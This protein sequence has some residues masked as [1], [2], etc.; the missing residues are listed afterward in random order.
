MQKR[1]AT[2]LI[3]NSLKLKFRTTLDL[4]VDAGYTAK[5]A[6]ANAKDIITSQGVVQA[7]ADMGFTESLAKATIANI[8]V[9]GKEENK[10]RAS[11]NILKVVGAYAPEK[12][13]NVNMSYAKLVEQ[14]NNEAKE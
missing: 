3:D 4:L 13:I 5:N 14:L 6:M 12:H 1:V 2:N 10:L 11:E 9:N 7:L 8:M